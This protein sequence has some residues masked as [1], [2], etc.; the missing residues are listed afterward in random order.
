M[1]YKLIINEEELDKF[2][3]WLPDLKKDNQ[4][5]EVFYMCLFAR[6]KYFQGIISSSNDKTQLRRELVKKHSIKRELRKWQCELGSYQLKKDTVPQEALVCYITPNP[7]SMKKAMF[8]LTK[9]LID[10]MG[11]N[12]VPHNL[13][14]SAI[15]AVQKEKSYTYVVDFDI[16]AKDVD[17]FALERILPSW[18]GQKCYDILQTRGGYHLLVK[19]QRADELIKIVNE[20]LGWNIDRNWYQKIQKSFYVDNSGDGMIPIPGTF[21]GGFTPK[22]LNI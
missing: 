22:F 13:H 2:I 21:Q 18:N 15:S 8:Q 16:D 1:N 3:E 9:D 14:Q 5:N 7:R 11:K 20:E 19:P 10:M 17:F 6:K 4:D 12:N